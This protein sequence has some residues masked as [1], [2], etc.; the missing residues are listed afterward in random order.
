MKIFR[1]DQPDLW[2]ALPDEFRDDTLRELVDALPERQRHMVS[3]VFFGGAP[4][5]WAAREIGVSP[6]TGRQILTEG[7]GVLRGALSEAD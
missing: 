1:E 4:L 7:L 6:P 3:R 5:A 2:E